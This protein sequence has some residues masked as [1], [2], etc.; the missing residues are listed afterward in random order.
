MTLECG[1]RPWEQRAWEPRWHGTQTGARR[2][3]E[4]ILDVVARDASG[5]ARLYIDATVRSP[6]AACYL[7]STP[8]SADEDGLA[9]FKGEDDKQ[10]RYPPCDGVRCT[11]AAVKHWGRTGVELDQLLQL[12]SGMAA[13]RDRSR[14][15]PVVRWLPRWCTELSCGIARVLAQTVA[16]ACGGGLQ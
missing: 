16:E 2:C 13:A 11:I 7:R 14:G 5:S 10:K 15:L 1:T 3:E 6:L 12:L 8:S 4:A 9:A